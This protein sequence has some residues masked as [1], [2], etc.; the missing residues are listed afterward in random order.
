MHLFHI[1]HQLCIIQ[2]SYC[3]Q[4]GHL[5]RQ[6]TWVPRNRQSSG[7]GEDGR[8]FQE[9]V[10]IKITCHNKEDGAFGELY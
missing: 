7:L 10:K 8:T 3:E 2:Y 5:S 4:N 1:M 6:L 9:E